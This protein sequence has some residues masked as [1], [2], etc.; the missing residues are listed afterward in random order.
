MDMHNRTHTLKQQLLWVA[1]TDARAAHRAGCAAG[2]GHRGLCACQGD[3]ARVASAQGGRGGG[4]RCR[5]AA[6]VL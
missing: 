6:R 3:G 4:S 5:A 2:G 1:H